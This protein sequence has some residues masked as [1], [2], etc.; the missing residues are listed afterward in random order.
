[1]KAT[2]TP[3][4]HRRID[5]VMGTI[6]SGSEGI[7]VCRC[8]T[9]VPWTPD[10]LWRHA[11]ACER[12]QERDG[13]EVGLVAARQA[14]IIDRALGDEEASPNGRP[15]SSRPPDEKGEQMA[16]PTGSRKKRAA[17][18][19]GGTPSRKRSTAAAAK[20]RTTEKGTSILDA[21]Y[22]ALDREVG[23][24]EKAP[25]SSQ[26]Y[27]RLRI[28]GKAFAYIYPPRPGSLLVK[29]PKAK[30]LDGIG[31]SLPKDHGFKKS[32]A[33]YGYTRTIV[34]QAEVPQIAKALKVAADA[35]RPKA[36]AEVA[37][38]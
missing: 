7:R 21:L 12:R 25:N 3:G 28:G 9:R 38:S 30:E 24:F 6:G 32:E 17:V 22:T 14:E 37:A 10:A 19:R 2:L 31:S 20:E 13:R 11:L 29:I 8:G 35:V 5:A 34:A 4:E 33:G 15:G 23:E 1:M 26:T 36:A 16:P 18:R 27:T